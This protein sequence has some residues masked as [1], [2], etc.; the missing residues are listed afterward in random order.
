MTDRI[1]IGISSCLLGEN[2]R[3]NGGYHQDRFLIE[4]LGQFVEYVP[5]CPEVE[6]GL[7]V[8][9][10]TLRLVG[11]PGNPRL[12]TTK[13]GIDHTDRMKQWAENRLKILEK[14]NLCGFIFKCDSPSSG[15]IRVKV[16]N[17]KGGVAK[18]GVGI[19]SRM[20]NA[21]RQCTTPLLEFRLWQSG[22]QNTTCWNNKGV[23]RF[24]SMR[25]K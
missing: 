2:V 13:T 15:M 14:E 21:F 4:T 16:Y 22:K 18:T 10:E 25:H 17:N 8:P 20:F 5:V 23:L 24:D 12:V 11:D 6:T 9:R 1:K 7:G 19:F 3:W